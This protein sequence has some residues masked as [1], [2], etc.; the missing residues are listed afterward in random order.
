MG[1]QPVILGGRY[2]VE[3]ELGRGGMAKV[4]RGTDTVLGR[5]VA[6]KVLAPRFSDDASFVQ[7]FRREAQAAARLS[8]PNV[9]GVFD[10]GT[11]DGVHYIV[12]EYVDGKTL[13]EYLAGGGRIMPERAIE[14]AEAVCEALAAAH[15]QGVI[16]RDIKPGNIMITPSGQVKVADF[17]IARMTTSAETV[18]QTAA[19]LGTAAYLSP[20]QAQGR[21]VDARSDLY[22]LGCVLYEM[23]TGRPPFTGDSPVAVASK[24]VLEP[25][26]PPSKLNPDVSPEL[27]AVILR[28]LAKNPDNRYA[29]AEEL[30]ADLERARRGLPVEATPVLPESAQTQVLRGG[31]RTEVLPPP[32]PPR[33]RWWIP[34][35]V[36]GGLLAA[37]GVLL[38]LFASDILGGGP[39]PSP[40]PKLVQVPEV[41]GMRVR[42]AERAL[43]DAGLTVGKRI[44][45]PIT[46]PATQ[47]PGVVVDQDPPAFQQV[48]EGTPVDLTVLVPPETVTIPP[49]EG[50][51]V[52]EATAALQALGFVVA[53]TREEPS[54]I[55]A[56]RVIGTDPPAGTPAPYGSEVTIVVSS[57]PAPVTV[58]DVVCFSLGQAKAKLQDAGLVPVVASE[59]K[60]PNPLCP[61]GSKVV[62]TDPDPFTPVQPGAQVL[63][64][65]PGPPP[66]PTGPSGPTGPTG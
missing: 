66:G 48:P 6:I 58:P 46:D 59:T 11:D 43:L 27:E 12:M 28:A 25:P 20:E 9:V 24:H 55:D 16:H 54:S 32:E 33:S 50:M 31:P 64:Y 65:L 44:E 62:D 53:G 35:L 30:R 52:E 36:I 42:A 18:E 8:N 1:E 7:R 60:P 51:T 15:A 47:E 56:G 61:K 40:T 5:P 13:A 21:P 26:T 3:Q 2:R 4:F 23:V 29:S 34:A 37:I 14:I 63:I 49:T 45:Q 10:T 57:G 41:I 38:W 19:V 39:K 22:S 17:G